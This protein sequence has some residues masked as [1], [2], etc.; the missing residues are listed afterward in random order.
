M[1]FLRRMRK[2]EIAREE[3]LKRRQKEEKQRSREKDRV[4]RKFVPPPMKRK[5]KI[6]FF[7]DYF[8]P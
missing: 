7:V 2:K 5:G 3:R 4:R 8:Y 1:F 6:K